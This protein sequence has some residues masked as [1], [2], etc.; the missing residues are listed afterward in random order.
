[1]IM[2]YQTMRLVSGFGSGSYASTY[3]SSPKMETAA[4]SS[5][6]LTQKWKLWTRFQFWAVST[7]GPAHAQTWTATRAVPKW[8]SNSASLFSERL[9]KITLLQISCGLPWYIIS[10]HA[11]QFLIEI[12]K[13]LLRHITGGGEDAQMKQYVGSFRNMSACDC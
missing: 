4:V 2:N 13:F 3:G 8:K 10:I 5:F 12:I 7:F 9:A 6:G 11:I 1:M